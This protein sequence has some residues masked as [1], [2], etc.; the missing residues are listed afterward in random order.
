ME[1][2]EEAYEYL[3]ENPNEELPLELDA[4]LSRGLEEVKKQLKE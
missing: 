4:P 2:L 1:E 3:L